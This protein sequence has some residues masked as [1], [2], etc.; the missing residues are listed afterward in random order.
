M[1]VTERWRLKGSADVLYL[2]YDQ[3]TGLLADTNLAV[4]YLPFKHAGFGLG[5]NSVRMKVEADG[6]NSQGPNLNG[7]LKFNFTGLLL[8][9]T[10]FF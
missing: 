5:I 7:E 6:D 4:E 10:F 9:A 3:F 8:Y 1:A 2:Q